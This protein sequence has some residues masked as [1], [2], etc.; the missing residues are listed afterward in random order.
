MKIYTRTGDNGTTGLFGGDRVSKAHLRMHAYGTIDELNA[1]LAVALSAADKVPD[2]LKGQLERI[3]DDL[4]ALGAD[5]ATPRTSKAKILR[6]DPAK[7]TELEGWIDMLEGRMEPLRQFLHMRGSLPGAELHRARTVCRRA[8]RFIVE[9]NEKEPLGDGV[10]QY[11]NRLSDYL[12]VA[13]RYMHR[14]AGQPEYPVTI[15]KE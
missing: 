15:K 8:E 4:F 2:D 14:W 6:T 7:A 9:L 3:Q 11:V 1:C 12:F 13:A 10:L 5:L